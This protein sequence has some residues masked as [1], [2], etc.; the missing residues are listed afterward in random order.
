MALDVFEYLNAL[1]QDRYR[2]VII[3]TSPEKSK[4]LTKFITRVGEKVKGKYIDLLDLFIQSKEL[5]ENIESF[6][7]EKFRNFIVDH[8]KPQSLLIIDRVDFLLDTW[9]KKDRDIFFQ[10]IMDQ[11][12]GFK[13]ATKAKLIMC[14]Q[15]S[16]EI[17][18]LKLI[19][20]RKNRILRLDD[21]TDI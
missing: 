12:D 4:A 10:I 13:E 21:F 19:E 15:T 6:R 11:W 5:R 3:H 7:P 16:I 18:N 2:A 8:S 17:E 20:S 9:R 14:L 1:D